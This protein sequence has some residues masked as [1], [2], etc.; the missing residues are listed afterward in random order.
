[1]IWKI[2]NFVSMQMKPNT[3]L[4][5]V[6]VD[7]VYTWLADGDGGFLHKKDWIRQVGQKALWQ[8]WGIIQL[9]S[10]SQAPVES[11]HVNCDVMNLL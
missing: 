1:M 8:S 11:S 5:L 3:F 4:G 2:Y 10:T 6:L 9:C 7:K